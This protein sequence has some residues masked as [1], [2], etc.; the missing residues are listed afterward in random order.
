[1]AVRRLLDTNTVLY[2]LSDRLAEPLAAG[3]YLA[4]VITEM[5][6][7]SYPLL[8]ARH[9]KQI[10]KSLSEV[11]IVSLSNEVKRVA[12]QLRRAHNLKLPDAII[13][14]TAVVMDAELLTNDRK[15]Q[16]VSGITARALVLNDA[17]E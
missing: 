13:A 14:A 2:L 15:L 7:L 17:V 5:E 11:E 6:L 8:E 16:S 12:I 3:E 10:Q 4:S 9:E 1:M